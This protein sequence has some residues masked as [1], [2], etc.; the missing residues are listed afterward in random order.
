[1]SASRN[2]ASALAAAERVVSPAP[3]RA[4]TNRPKTLGK[5]EKPEA[6]ASRKG[7]EAADVSG[8]Q[9]ALMLDTK[10]ARVAEWES[11]EKPHS[12]PTRHLFD[13]NAPR[14]WVRMMFAEAGSVHMFQVMDTVDVVHGH[15][16]FA[17]LHA[18]ES[19]SS[20]VK[21]VIAAGLASDGA[22]DLNELEEVQTE[23]R[24]ALAVFLEADAFVA[25]EIKRLRASK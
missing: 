4:R 1:M 23:I 2:S 10:Q 20:D 16:H 3:T 14:E 12:P 17:R 15:N 22:L 6:R 11:L 9:L 21:R 7:R 24:Q 8:Q 19:E 18:L 5:I 25:S 13:P